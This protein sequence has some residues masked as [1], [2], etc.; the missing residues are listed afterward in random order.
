MTQSEVRNMV[1]GSAELVGYFQSKQVL[2]EKVYRA[3]PLR[4]RVRVR[5][6]W[7]GA[8]PGISGLCLLLPDLE[9]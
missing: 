9:S 7:A 3:H 5:V 4:V 8:P 2:K 1:V 6:A